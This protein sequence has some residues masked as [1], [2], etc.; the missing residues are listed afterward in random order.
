MATETHQLEGDDDATTINSEPVDPP[1]ASTSVAN[2]YL[3]WTR[4][5]ITAT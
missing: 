4:S 2:T 1:I 5:P 3:R